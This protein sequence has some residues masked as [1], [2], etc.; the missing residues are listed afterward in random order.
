MSKDQRLDEELINITGLYE[1]IDQL[2]DIEQIKVATRL[3]EL[4]RDVLM[5]DLATIRRRATAQARA[6]GLS[7][8]E[9]AL[10]SDS[11]PQTINRLLAERNSYGGGR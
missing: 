8:K 5:V 9:I 4:C 10:L 7:T 2:P 11:S 1:K 6:R 3:I